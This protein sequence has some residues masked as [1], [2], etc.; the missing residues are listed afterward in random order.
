MS[1]GSVKKNGDAPLSG[2]TKE[3]KDILAGLMKD[4]GLS[5]RAMADVVGSVKRG[6][7]GWADSLNTG[8]A[9]QK[10]AASQGNMLVRAPTVGKV[11]AGARLVQPPA[12][13]SGK[14]MSGAI[15]R[16]APVGREQYPGSAPA[17]D[18]EV[19]KGRLQALM[20]MGP[21]GVA[22]MEAKL[23]RL[24]KAAME[25]AR[26]PRPE[27]AREAMIDQVVE[28][29]RERREF[30]EAMRVAGRSAEHEVSLKAEISQRLRELERLGMDLQRGVVCQV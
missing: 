3:T 25:P 17:P 27:E 5:H 30:L 15:L 9:K 8:I 22:D 14:R 2:L 12:S 21:K 24:Q 7:G 28:E 20:E 4:R 23:L 18:R 16:D 11:T 29:I 1:W 10:P 26:Q 6:D 19:E 13:F